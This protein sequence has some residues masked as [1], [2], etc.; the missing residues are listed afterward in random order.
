MKHSFKFIYLI[1][2][3]VVICIVVT[4]GFFIMR[5]SQE[6]IDSV[7]LSL[8]DTSEFNNI[9]AIYKGRQKGSDV[10]MMLQKVVNNANKNSQ[11]PNMLLDVAYKLHATDEFTIINSTKKINNVTEI[12]SLISELDVKHYYTVEFVYSKETDLINGIIIKYAQKDKINFIPD[13]N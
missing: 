8:T 10:K 5:S 11:N 1:S 2:V 13:E 3:I 12:K 4:L 7:D 9:W 6:Y